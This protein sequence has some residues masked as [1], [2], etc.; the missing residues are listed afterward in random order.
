MTNR[1][2]AREEAEVRRGSERPYRCGNCSGCDGARNACGMTVDDDGYRAV[3]LKARRRYILGEKAEDAGSERDDRPRTSEEGARMGESMGV[4]KPARRQKKLCNT[5]GC[6]NRAYKSGL[7]Y[8]CAV[9]ANGGKRLYP[10]GKSKPKNTETIFAPGL[11]ERMKAVREWA[12]FRSIK[13]WA[14][15]LKHDNSVIGTIE[16]GGK[17]HCGEEGKIILTDKICMAFPG[18]SREWIVAGEGEMR[19]VKEIAEPIHKRAASTAGGGEVDHER[20]GVPAADS[21]QP[22]QSAGKAGN[23]TIAVKT[24]ER[25]T[26]RAGPR[27]ADIYFERTGGGIMGFARCETELVGPKEAQG[28]DATFEDWMFLGRVAGEIAALQ[29]RLSK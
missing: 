15:F 14:G 23:P 26:L 2:Y 21:P 10:P 20:D 27:T 6:G 5:E 22:V 12:G 17:K 28:A 24:A 29:E 11:G 4:V 9:K 19:L 16:N 1:L 7:C 18:I 3:Q 13:P 8:G 25:Y